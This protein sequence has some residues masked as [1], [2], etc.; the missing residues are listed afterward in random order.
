MPTRR[1][2]RVS[3]RIHEEISAL[4]QREMGDPR[5]ANVTVTGV[6]VSPDLKMASIFISALGD[7]EA[8]AAALQGLQHASSYV[9]WQLAQ[10]IQLRYTPELLFEL[11]ESWQR[12]A[13]IDELLEQVHHDD[14]LEE[15]PGAEPEDASSSG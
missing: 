14:A 6:E 5:L 1:Q 11:D 10:R 4:L 8:R 3:E 12:G 9:R 15:S 13:R 2:E 7:R